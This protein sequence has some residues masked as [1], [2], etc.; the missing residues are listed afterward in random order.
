MIGILDSGETGEARREARGNFGVLRPD[1]ALDDS[2]WAALHA[3]PL[4]QSC[5][6]PQHSIPAANFL[7]RAAGYAQFIQGVWGR[8]NEMKALTVP[9]SHPHS[10]QTAE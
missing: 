2:C 4:V 10:F 9:L 6:V 3:R 7:S 1:A 5:V 8:V